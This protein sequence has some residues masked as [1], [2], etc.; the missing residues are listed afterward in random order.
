MPEE[1]TQLQTFPGPTASPGDN[2]GDL[3]TAP[4]PAGLSWRDR[5][6]VH[7]AADRYPM[8]SGDEFEQ[9]IKDI[10]KN[11][12]REGIVLWTPEQPETTLPQKVYVLDGRNRLDAIERAF[13]H[14]PAAYG[15]KI[16]K[17]LCWDPSRGG[18]AHLLYGDTDPFKASESLNL[19]RRHLTSKKK[20]ELIAS[21]VR[22]NPERSDREIARLAKATP[23]TAG[24]V[25]AAL[26]ESGDVSKL[27]TRPDSTG[28]IQRAHKLPR[29]T[30]QTRSGP[31][32]SA[33]HARDFAITGFSKILH[34]Q[35]A[36][37]LDDLTRLLR[38]ERARIEHIPLPRRVVLAQEFLSALGLTV[39]G[40]RPVDGHGE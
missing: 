26:E 6:E 12:Q 19:H 3:F 15:D 7:P 28:R 37:T 33:A 38:N 8:M 1:K 40:L 17:A 2:I 10:A 29:S 23:T 4:N 20:R 13:A 27:D 21:L 39:D 25:R 9:F 32:P 31:K 24:K 35:P 5:V 36:D 22:E 16:V 11:G 34:H 18:T 14:D 30:L